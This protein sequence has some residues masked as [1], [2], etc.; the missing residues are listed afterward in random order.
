MRPKIRKVNTK[1][2]KQERKDARE[3]LAEEASQMLSNHPTECC[4]CHTKFERTQETVKT[5]NVT[6]NES[7]VRLTCPKCWG[8]IKD[9]IERLDNDKT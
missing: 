6:I 9:R 5:W 3:R 8:I 2:R 4:V 1:K 7:R